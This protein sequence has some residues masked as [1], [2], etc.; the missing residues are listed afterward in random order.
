MLNY[1]NYG[2]LWRVYGLGTLR[3]GTPRK[4]WNAART[5]WAYRR[6][7]V[8]TRTA[9]Y[10]LHL[11]PHYFCN[12]KCPL[13]QR[14]RFSGARK[15]DAGH[16]SLDVLDS[17][18]DEI[19]DYLIQCHIFGLSEP[20]LNWPLTRQIIEKT[21]RRRI[22]TLVSTNATLITPDMAREMVASGLD[23]LVCAIDGT[24]QESYGKYRVNGRFDDAIRGLRLVAAERDRQRSRIQIEWQYLVNAFTADEMDEARRMAS[25]MG[26]YVRFAPMGG[27]EHDKELQDYWLPKSTQ[28]Q[29]SR[30]ETGKARNK[31]ACYWL[32]RGAVVNSNGQMGRCPGYQNV[33]QMGSVAEKS[34]MKLYNGPLSQRA[35]QLFVKGPVPPGD[36]PAPCSTCMFYPREHGGPNRDYPW[37]EGEAGRQREAPIPLTMAPR[38][39]TVLKNAPARQAEPVS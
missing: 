28:W 4:L 14:Q 5:E 32:W 36:F 20:S 34:F 39:T 37:A 38:E 23:Y 15:A 25:E 1:Q 12:L 16:L 17:I 19:G 11:E 33:A 27:M 21:H 6:R 30:I 2:R 9:P 13:C 26:V 29:D 22:F 7:R 24:S 3:Y 8:D 18:L 31:W 10:V 35:R